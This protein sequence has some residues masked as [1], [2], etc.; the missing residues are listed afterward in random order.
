[1]WCSEEVLASDSSS[2]NYDDEE[3]R[4][5]WIFLGAAT[6]IIC[7]AS[8]MLP[9]FDGIVELAVASAPEDCNSSSASKEEEKKNSDHQQAPSHLTSPLPKS[10]RPRQRRE[11]TRWSE[12]EDALLR[13]AVAHYGERRW[14][15]I[16]GMVGSRS[17]KQCRERWISILSPSLVHRGLYWSRQDDALL[18]RLARATRQGDRRRWVAMLEHFP[19][20]SANEVKNRWNTIRKQT[21][22]VVMSDEESG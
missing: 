16:S 20:R 6:E 18:L 14:S 5:S 22:R 17:S 8:P 7:P 3:T 10:R 19:G 13:E 9:L 4:P 1:M 15:S 11:I 2:E 21:R 12:E